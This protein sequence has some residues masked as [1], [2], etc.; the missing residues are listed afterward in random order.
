MDVSIGVN[1][2][3]NIGVNISVNIG[4]NMLNPI[5]KDKFK[6]GFKWVGI[7]L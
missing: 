7:V 6:L 5:S 1:M 4:V 3:V 2:V